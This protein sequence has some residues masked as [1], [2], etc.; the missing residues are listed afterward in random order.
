MKRISISEIIQATSG[1]LISG[2]P[3]SMVDGVSTDSRTAEKDMLFIALK[4]EK[5]D[6]H[7]FLD[8]AIEAGCSALIISKESGSINALAK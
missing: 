8:Q 5:H 4:G 3:S 7:D 6:G 1:E 2:D